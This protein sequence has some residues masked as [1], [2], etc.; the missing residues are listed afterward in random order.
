MIQAKR[1]GGPKPPS[2]VIAARIA[3]AMARRSVNPAL[4]CGTA[5]NTAVFLHW[6]H[7]QAG[8]ANA[9]R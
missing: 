2:H 6:Q 8:G 4:K 1:K 5:I 7:L 9:S 3:E